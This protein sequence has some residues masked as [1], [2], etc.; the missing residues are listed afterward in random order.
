MGKTSLDRRT[1]LTAAAI[2][3][4]VGSVFP[5]LDETLFCVK[6]GERVPGDTDGRPVLVAGIWVYC[7]TCYLASRE[8]PAVRLRRIRRNEP[9]PLSAR[10][11]ED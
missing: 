11:L 8:R 10:R 7:E 1:F 9:L 4:V 2:S 5:H 6:C 3:P